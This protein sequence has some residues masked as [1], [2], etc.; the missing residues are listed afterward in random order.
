MNFDELTKQILEKITP[1]Q[2]EQLKVDALRRRL[3]QKIADACVSEGVS[4]IV[5]VEG[6]IAKDT[7]LSGNPDID[8]FIRLP[9][10]VPREKLGEVGLRIAKKAAGDAEQLERFA[11]HP[12]LEIFVEGYRVDIVPCY[13]AKHGDW[14]SATDR[15]PYHTDYIKTHLGKELTGEVRLLKQFMQGIGVYGA[16]IKIGGFSGYLCELLVMHFGSFKKIIEAFAD[17][18]Q[19]LVIDI[20]SFY[21]ERERELELLFPEPLV[22]VDPVDQG[23]NVASAV[24]SSKLYGLIGA[25]REFLKMPGEDFFY[26]QLIHAT[27]PVT[28]E[29]HHG[30]IG[31]SHLYVVV[32]E[33]SAVPD[34]LWG[35]LYRSKRSLS[36]LLEVNDFVVL[37]DAVWSNEKNFS[38][39]IFELEQNVLPNV[40]KH[41]GP[42]LS[43]RVECDKFIAKY[44]ADTSVLSG[45]YIEQGRWVVELPRKCIDA[46]ALLKEKLSDGGKNAGVA[47]L[48]ADAIKTDLKVLLDN[49]VLRLYTEHSDFAVFLTQFM[50]GKPFWLKSQTVQS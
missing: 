49:E 12:Y 28:V 19:R 4:A 22:I 25:A 41:L 24:Q 18:S 16:E 36:K 45:P 14:Q 43:R 39:F 20:G 30:S 37:R 48:V 23:R 29:D 34:V 15:T 42:P 50:A 21:A 1:K 17:Y 35:Q 31:S 38:V 46:A 9:P 8:I 6:S 33:L 13:D 27:S 11:E 10:S 7:W 44:V 40:K 5:R 3:E 32:G 2:D 47:E 26:P